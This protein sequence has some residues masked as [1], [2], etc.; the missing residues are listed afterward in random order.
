MELIYFLY[1]IDNYHVFLDKVIISLFYSKV[2]LIDL[3]CLS[4]KLIK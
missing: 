2:I 4:T 1:F 3:I